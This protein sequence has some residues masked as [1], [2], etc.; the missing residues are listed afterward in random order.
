MR[1][2]PRPRRTQRAPTVGGRRGRLRKGRVYQRWQ[3]GGQ[4]QLLL[5]LLLTS[6]RLLQ[7]L[8]QSC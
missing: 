6:W 3:A 2:S 5:L 8:R 1:P 4:L 7:L